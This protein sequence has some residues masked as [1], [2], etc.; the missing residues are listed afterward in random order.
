MMKN[1]FFTNA[2]KRAASMAGKPGRLLILFS[3]LALKLKAI[4]WKNLK[5]SEVKGRF[6]VLGRLI[7][8]YSLGHY[9][10][11]PWKSMLIIIAAVI[12]FINPIDL[13]P[14]V[15][16]LVGFTDDFGILLWVYNTVNIEIDK[17]LVWEREH[18]TA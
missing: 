11:V 16:P 14:D 3:R 10:D 2:L 6:L 13:L 15:L 9:R 1:I 4:D 7:K 8:A 17:F 18:I 12:Y 5:A